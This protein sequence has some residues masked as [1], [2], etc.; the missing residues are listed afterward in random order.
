MVWNTTYH[1]V[2]DGPADLEDSIP[3]VLSA[4]GSSLNVFDSTSLI[5]AV[6]KADKPIRVD[7][8]FIKVYET[9]RNIYQKSGGAFDPT[10]SPLITAWG[11][12]AGHKATS[13]T[14]RIDS[15]LS[16]SG[17]DKT[18]LKANVLTKKDPRTLFN[19]SA[20]A[21]G[22]GCDCIADMF[23]RNGVDNFLVEIGGEIVAQGV[24]ADHTPW[25]ISIDRPLRT[26]SGVAHDSHAIIH[27]SNCGLATSGNYRN[28]H[29]DGSNVYGHTI[30]PT[31]GRPVTTDV[32]SASVIANN[33]ME[34]DAVATACMVLGSRQGAE[35]CQ[36]L[37]L[38]YMF[39]LADTTIYSDS[40]PFL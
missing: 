33:A 30:S 39:I 40:F 37:K 16:F 35:L 27:L 17:L 3:A 8:H 29:R 11:F 38:P 31:T 7:Q 25:T 18:S 32:L 13:D 14:L 12:G 2:W 20:V 21:K 4:V 1:I 28:Y 24:N 10:L 23:R 22:Y 6:N 5:S 9:S 19:F 34:A 36:K 26:D 15:L